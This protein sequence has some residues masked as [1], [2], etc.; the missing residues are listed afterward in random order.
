[1]NVPKLTTVSD[2]TRRVRLTLIFQVSHSLITLPDRPHFSSSL[3][4]H[5]MSPA[6]GPADPQR[7]QGQHGGLAADSKARAAQEP[8]LHTPPRTP[9]QSILADVFGFPISLQA[10][11]CPP[12]T[13]LPEDW[14]GLFPLVLQISLLCLYFPSSSHNC[15]KFNSCT[16]SLIPIICMMALLLDKH[17]YCYLK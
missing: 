14:G 15:V 16:K 7:P 9:P 13:V 2:E 6:V 5:F 10:P 3:L 11:T 12:A 1:M 4:A 8:S 17:N